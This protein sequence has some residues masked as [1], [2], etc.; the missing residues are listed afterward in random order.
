[1]RSRVRRFTLTN[2]FIALVVAQF[3]IF[4][5]IGLLPYTL[6]ASGFE[7]FPI[8]SVSYE[9]A[10]L[11]LCIT[12]SGLLFFSTRF[13]KHYAVLTFIL[14]IFAL[15]NIASVTSGEAKL[16]HITIFIGIFASHIV[17][18]VLAQHNKNSILCFGVWAA[19]V[20]L[21]LSG[22]SAYLLLSDNIF[23]PQGL[24]IKPVFPGK[25][26]ST[27]LSNI[28]GLATIST[29]FWRKVVTHKVI[30]NLL[31]AF[32]IAICIWFMSLGT[33]L[34]L[35]IISMMSN[36]RQNFFGVLLGLITACVVLILPF[37]VLVEVEIL[38]SR[39]LITY[40][41]DSFFLRLGFYSDLINLGIQYPLTGIGIGEFFKPPHHNLLGLWAETGVISVLTY[42]I[43]S[44]LGLTLAYI[45]VKNLRIDN[46]HKF[47][48]AALFFAALFIFLKGLVHDTWTNKIFYFA[49]A[50]VINKS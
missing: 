7:R 32:S 25:V 20:S 19:G 36:E 37:W 41:D 6:T 44:I 50:Y 28:A 42:A 2:V 8:K 48:L 23:Y 10:S 4:S 16:T 34:V 31:M 47:F 46:Q 30:P 29:F 24:G 3:L 40:L 18:G 14:I 17:G 22:I 39:W 21:L 5:S 26:V 27:E 9:M 38:D 49:I 15:V 43:Y 45:K 12:I 33:I 1:M 11:L 35:I 13:S